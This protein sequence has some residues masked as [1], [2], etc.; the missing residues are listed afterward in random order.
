MLRQTMEGGQPVDGFGHHGDPMTGND[1]RDRGEAA[2]LSV[3][4]PAVSLFRPGQVLADRPAGLPVTLD[5]KTG[6]EIFLAPLSPLPLN[7]AR[8]WESI[9]PLAPDAGRLAARGLFVEGAKDGPAGQFDILRTRLLQ[10]IGPRKWTRIAITAPTAGAGTSLVAANLALSLARLPSCRTVLMDLCL[11]TPALAP[12]FG[13]REAPDLTEFLRGEQPLEATFRRVGRNLALAVNGTQVEA[14]SEL[15]H[16]PE[17]ALA[18]QAMR[19]LLQPDV[20][21]IDAP[22]ALASDEFLALGAHVDAVLLV[23]DASRTS[24][25]EIRATERLIDGRLPLL[26]VVLNRARD[27][28]RRLPWLRRRG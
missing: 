14:S 25:D 21:L 13:L 9:G 11:R 10:A 5:Q 3:R 26:G 28:A 18:L 8:V 23:T 15:L 24:P 7:P 6:R 4:G 17:T 12:L 20:V 16:D 19:D 1:P 2:R 22:P 27:R